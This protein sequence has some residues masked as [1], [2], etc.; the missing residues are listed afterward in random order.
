[1][2]ASILFG[3]GAVIA[4]SWVGVSVWDRFGYRQGDRLFACDKSKWAWMCLAGAI[5][6]TKLTWEC[7]VLKAVEVMNVVTIQNVAW[8]GSNGRWESRTKHRSE[9]MEREREGCQ[10]RACFLSV[11]ANKLISTELR[12]RSGQFPAQ[13]TRVRLSVARREMRAM[14]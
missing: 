12:V 7:F 2:L 14:R 10:E 9:T 5:E 11:L 3:F 4:F 13:R 6:N 1:M 8:N